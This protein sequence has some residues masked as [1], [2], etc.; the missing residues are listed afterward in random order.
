MALLGA[1]RAAEG[2]RLQA[3]TKTCSNS[4]HFT[5]HALSRIALMHLDV[6]CRSGSCTGNNDDP[7]QRNSFRS[8][9][10]HS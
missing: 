10:A 7:K 2:A 6:C 3:A 5:H 9:A 8:Y 1:L 4:M